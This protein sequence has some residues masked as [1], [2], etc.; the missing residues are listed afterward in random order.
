MV[1]LELRFYQTIEVSA[2]IIIILRETHKMPPKRGYFHDLTAF[3]MAG[4]NW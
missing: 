1:T 4:D 3:H 2:I